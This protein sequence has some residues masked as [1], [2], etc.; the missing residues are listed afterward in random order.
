M[1]KSYGQAYLN[2]GGG[3]NADEV[4]LWPTADLGF[5]DPALAVNVVHGIT[6]KDD[7]ETFRRHYEELDR[8]SAPWELA[9]LYEAH[10]VIDPRETR[11]Y[12]LNLLDMY[13]ARGI[14][15]RL[16]HSWPTSFV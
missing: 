12:L 8:D 16:L 7:P 13:H 6:E 4:A 9:E 14:G 11:D 15:E 10:D 3:R 2:M 5:M 1:R